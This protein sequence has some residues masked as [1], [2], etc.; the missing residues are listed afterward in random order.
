MTTGIP[1]RMFC[2]VIFLFVGGVDAAVPGPPSTAVECGSVGIEDKWIADKNDNI[3]GISDV[4]KISQPGV[5]DYQEL[6]DATPEVKKMIKEG[7]D[8]DSPEGK[9]LRNQAKTRIIK[10]CQK[11][12]ASKG[13]DSVWKKISHTGSKKARDITNAVKRLF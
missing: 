1:L 2:A 3:C 6:W 9:T 10:A 4:K 8:P 11:I 13:L 5:A 7:I 12:Q